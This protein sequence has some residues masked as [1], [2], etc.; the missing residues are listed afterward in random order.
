M[1]QELIPCPFC[2]NNPKLVEISGNQ[3]CP[4]GHRVECDCGA[5][6]K[7]FET[8]NVYSGMSNKL[9]E[10]RRGDIKAIEFWN[11]RKDDK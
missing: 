5:K 6:G 3:Q 9:I 7:F 4:G 11:N 8:C 10:V 1:N 2:G